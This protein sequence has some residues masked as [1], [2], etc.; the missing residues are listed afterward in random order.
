MTTA[1]LIAALLCAAVVAIAFYG[2]F[3]Q[4]SPETPA[5]E[6]RVAVEVAPVT[7]HAIDDVREFSGSLEASARLTVA[8]K[9]AGQIERVAVDIGDAIAPGDPLVTLDDD[10][11][12]QA[13]AEAEARLEVARAELGQAQS[14][15]ANARRTLARVR[16][17]ND[18]GI[19]A[20]AEL[21]DAESQTANANA[22]LS[23]AR[24]GIA[25][26]KAQVET[27]RVRLSYTRIHA[28]WPGSDTERVVGER[29][30]E[31]GDTVAANTPLLTVVSVTPLT[32]VIQ[33]PE[34]IYTGLAAGQ[35][36][37][38]RVAGAAEAGH[39]ATIA[40]IAPVF[41]PDTRR[42]RVELSVANDARALAPGMFVQVGLVTEHLDA[43][44]VVPRAALVERGGET[45]VFIVDRPTR[46]AHFRPVDVAF[47]NHDRAA[48]RAPAT[49]S[50]YV[51]TLGQAQLE[52]GIAVA[53]DE[54]P[55]SA[56][57]SAAP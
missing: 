1:R 25:E 49:L 23:V 50:G 35:P 55:P 41:D 8:P 34:T 12:R 6:R 21:D 19:A 2:L 52:D 33:V 9:I 15:A 22:A 48:I 30:V 31:P 43:A 57:P 7:R 45:G 11:Y 18:K 29:S 39:T 53:F 42:A 27:A 54:P 17:L 4:Q 40:R 56:D 24:A 37:Q 51:V 36:A 28:A 5:G 47:T 32:A 38:L 16:S 14:D 26:A 46:T 3:G 44:P 13:L 10:E 20:N